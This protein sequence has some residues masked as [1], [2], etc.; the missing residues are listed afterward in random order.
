MRHYDRIVSMI[1]RYVNGVGITVLFV[2]IFVTTA[3]V[4]GRYMRHPIPGAFE[5]V[6]MGLAIAVFFGVAY[7]ALQRGHISVDWFV[8]RLSNRKRLVVGAINSVLEAFCWVLVAW[9]GYKYAMRTS[10]VVSDTLGINLT[11]SKLVVPFGA[12]LLVLVVISQFVS[13]V[14]QAR[15]QES[16]RE[17]TEK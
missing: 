11:F 8:E 12:L 10:M 2:L 4:I 13:S 1:V 7:T 17:G 3:D 6:E 5:L 14:R 9:Q 15:N 16:Q